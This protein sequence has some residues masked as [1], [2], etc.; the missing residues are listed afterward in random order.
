MFREKGFEISF[1]QKYVLKIEAIQQGEYYRLISSS[2]LHV[3]TN[4]LLF[5]MLTLFFFG[6][7]VV[8]YFGGLLF[9][10]YLFGQCSQ[11]EPLRCITMR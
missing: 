11:R 5:N 10:V 2:F 9:L 3:D 1:F 4:H 6:D 7:Y 8:S